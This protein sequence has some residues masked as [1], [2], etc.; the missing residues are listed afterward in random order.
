[1]IEE[2]VGHFAATQVTHR[3]A[4]HQLDL[5][6]RLRLPV[7]Q[8]QAAI[9]VVVFRER[10]VDLTGLE[11]TQR[12]LHLEAQLFFDRGIPELRPQQR[13]LVARTKRIPQRI[14]FVVDLANHRD[15]PPRAFRLHKMIVR[16][17]TSGGD[18]AELWFFGDSETDQ[19][20]REQNA[21]ACR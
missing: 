13:D 16:R 8:L 7:Q 17:P 5:K 18:A 9:N 6:R 1:M 14:R 21:A 11:K 20:A 3:S 10:L 4:R 12:D 19:Q 15:H 2:T